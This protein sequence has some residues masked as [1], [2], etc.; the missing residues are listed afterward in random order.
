MN[1]RPPA[2]VRRK[3]AQSSRSLRSRAA[4]NRGMLLMLGPAQTLVKTILTFVYV[5]CKY[6][7]ME[8]S[9]MHLFKR[10]YL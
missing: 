10:D 8:M 5:L 1:G 6:R 9:S 4:F 7:A 3:A 2:G